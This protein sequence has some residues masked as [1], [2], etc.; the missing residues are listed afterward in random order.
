MDNTTGWLL[1]IVIVAVLY[2]LQLKE[3]RKW[4]SSMKNAND[5]WYELL[6]MQSKHIATI[7]NQN[8]KERQQDYEMLKGMLESLEYHSS[9]L[10]RIEQKIDPPKKGA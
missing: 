10:T 4:R 9:I 6:A 7:I 2:I 3:A 1:L 8:D 5:K